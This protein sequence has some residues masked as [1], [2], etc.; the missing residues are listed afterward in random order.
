MYINGETIKTLR[1]QQKLTQKQL[2]ESIN[3][4]EKAVS[5]WECG[6]GLP[7][8]SLIEPLAKKLGVSVTELMT[9][10]VVKNVN[11]NANMR[12]S[13]FYVCPVCNNILWSMGEGC[14]TCCGEKL[15]K[16]I[17]EQSDEIAAD[18]VIVAAPSDGGIFVQIKHPMEKTHSILFIAFISNLGTVQIAKL[19]PEQNAECRFAGFAKGTVYAFCNRHG[20]F[21]KEIK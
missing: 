15:E 5:K 9:N 21:S 19:Y 6:H 13:G 2:A 12:R 16:A 11:K 14:F 8:I 20:I 4:S 3:V 7:D 18:H 1:L 10:A 17:P